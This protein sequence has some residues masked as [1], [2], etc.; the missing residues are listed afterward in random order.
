VERVRSCQSRSTGENW[1][2]TER[3]ARI[4]PAGGLAGWGKP[5]PKRP[6]QAQSSRQLP[7]A[8]ALQGAVRTPYLPHA[9]EPRPL[10]AT[11]D[12][13][14]QTRMENS[15][16]H[17]FRCSPC[18]MSTALACEIIESLD[19]SYRHHPASER[20]EASFNERLTRKSYTAQASHHAWRMPRRPLPAPERTLEGVSSINLSEATASA[21]SHLNKP[22]QCPSLMGGCSLPALDRSPLQ[23][24]TSQ[25]ISRQSL[26]FPDRVERPRSRVGKPQQKQNSDQEPLL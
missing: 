15:T 19:L 22:F 1:E 11:E 17:Y 20:S 16:E 14:Q 24:P 18:H 26:P 13:N 3:L 8:L 23:L 10:R 9:A 21:Q 4:C 6:T 25:K 12:G 2:G 5:S 7:A